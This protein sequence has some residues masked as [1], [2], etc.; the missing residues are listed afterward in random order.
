M[1]ELEERLKGTGSE[2]VELG[3]QE[4]EVAEAQ[5]RLDAIGADVKAKRDRRLGLK[6][7]LGLKDASDDEISRQRA[8]FM[9][10]R[11]AAELEGLR[12]DQARYQ[13]KIA[14]LKAAQEKLQDSISELHHDLKAYQRGYDDSQAELNKL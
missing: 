3:S 5:R 9:K 1:K 6:D 14:D 13:R 11:N 12:A 2:L 4:R 8:E 7:D 10:M